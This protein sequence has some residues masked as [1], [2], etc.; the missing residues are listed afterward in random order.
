MW[1]HQLALRDVGVACST[2]AIT[3]VR[4]IQK[5]GCHLYGV[6][7]ENHPPNVS[8]SS[9]ILGIF[10]NKF[11]KPELA[12][13]EGFDK[14]AADTTY[15]QLGY[16]NATPHYRPQNRLCGMPDLHANPSHI[17]A[18]MTRLLQQDTK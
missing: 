18:S 6:K 4:Y 2:E 14:N 7:G 17:A 16:T 9:S 15:R 3:Y 8:L 11:S 12:C 10:F 13:G 5:S 1:T